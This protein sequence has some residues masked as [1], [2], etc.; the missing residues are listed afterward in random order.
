[1]KLS[2]HIL[3][4]SNCS[5]TIIKINEILKREQ[6]VIS[7]ESVDFETFATGA[8]NVDKYKIVYVD[9][10]KEEFLTTIKNKYILDNCKLIFISDLKLNPERLFEFRPFDFLSKPIKDER[11]KESLGFAI[12]DLSTSFNGHQEQEM[13]N[14]LNRYFI[15]EKDKYFWITLDDIVCFEALGN[16]VKIHLENKVI[17]FYNTLN[18]LVK[19]L[20]QGLF[21][22]ANRS[23]LVNLNFVATIKNSDKGMIKLILKNKFEV[24]LSQR[25]TVEFRGKMA[26]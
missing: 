13:S 17:I 24:E 11:F 15:K 23:F 9:F 1:M 8:V 10:E 6:E 16:Y 2:L 21:F 14:I 5:N 4:V 26:L 3:V 25:Q 7:M 19:R 22:R 20:P 12:N 18:N